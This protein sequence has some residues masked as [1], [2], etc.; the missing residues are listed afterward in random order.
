MMED[1]DAKEDNTFTD[2]TL[3]MPREQNL[4]DRSRDI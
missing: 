4:G 1:A 2:F 3:G